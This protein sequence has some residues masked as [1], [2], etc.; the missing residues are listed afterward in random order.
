[1]RRGL[2]WELPGSRQRGFNEQVMSN[3][4]ATTLRPL[5]AKACNSDEY[6]RDLIKNRD[7]SYIEALI[8]DAGHSGVDIF[9][10]NRKK[11]DEERQSYIEIISNYSAENPCARFDKIA[12]EFVAIQTPNAIEVHDRMDG[13]Y[14][15][16]ID[17]SLQSGWGYLIDCAHFFY[18]L[19]EPLLFARFVADL[20]QSSVIHIPLSEERNQE[21]L[22]Y[23]RFTKLNPPVWSDWCHSIVAKFLIGHEMGHIFLNHFANGAG[24]RFQLA[25]DGGKPAVFSAFNHALE[26]EADAWAAKAL[27]VNK[28]S[29]VTHNLSA[30]TIPAVCLSLMAMMDD[31]YAP[32]DPLGK[33]IYDSHPPPA[34]RA[35]KLQLMGA[36]P[37]GVS[38]PMADFQALQ[39]LP[40]FINSIRADPAFKKYTQWF[41]SRTKRVER[42]KKWPHWLL[43]IA[44]WA[45]SLL[46]S[47]RRL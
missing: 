3:L 23:V 26:F 36:L 43:T 14:A 22:D 21:H 28:A 38:M 33:I 4:A 17:P 12:F 2:F 6:I 5:A 11:R 29:S 16:G 10:F 20:V 1:M 34:E 39:K 31:F 42:M 7:T 18:R 37:T 19:N 40:A 41:R 47:R 32:T 25:Q 45:G 44:G 27:L 46:G 9:E 13:S 30:R 24:C 35:V 8:R 15:I